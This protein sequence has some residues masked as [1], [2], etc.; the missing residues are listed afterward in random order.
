MDIFDQNLA[1]G[2]ESSRQRRAC[3]DI[4]LHRVYRRDR[5][6]RV[7]DRRAA[8]VAGVGDPRDALE[9]YGRAGV[10][11]PMCVGD[12]TDT[13]NDLAIGIE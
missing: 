8:D 4:A 6:K 2:R 11:V 10:E 1:A 9:C 5:L 13:Q 12:H 3:V 7:N